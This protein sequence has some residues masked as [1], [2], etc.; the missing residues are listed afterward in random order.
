MIKRLKWKFVLINMLSVTAV[1]LTVFLAVFLTS[2]QSLRE[3]SMAVLERVIATDSAPSLFSSSGEVQIPYFTVR[4][5]SDGSAYLAGGSYY[6]FESQQ[7]LQ[8]ILEECLAQQQTSGVLER[9]HL[10]YLRSSSPFWEKIAFVD[11]SFE[12]ATLRSLSLSMLRF[13][14]P[15]LLALF[16]VSLLLAARAVRPVEASM[17]RQRQ[18]LSDASHELKTPLTVILSNT[19]LLQEELPEGESR[20]W[21]GNI[22]AESRRMKSLVEEM[23]TLERSEAPHAAPFAPL[24]LSELATEEVLRFEP[25]AFEAGKPLR[26]SIQE[27][28][29]LSGNAEQLHRLLA[30]LL[31]NA[32]RYGEAGQGIDVTL[33]QEG[34]RA[35]L[36][37]SNAAPPLTKEQL[38][39]LFE[40]F[41][42]S[43]ASRGEQSGFGLGLPIARAIARQ[44]GGDLKAESAA[45]RL[46]FTAS[47]PLRNA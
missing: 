41:Y 24:S 16:F 31:D 5:F 42:R 4:L 40:R 2:R 30:V 33:R 44:H 13:M 10:R 14:L 17:E 15:A 28:I 1:L 36:S 3:S 38:S 18:F 47:L 12:T 7:Q 32:I 37:V 29:T 11:T 21:L 27:N 25:L 22:E 45:G 6:A 20:R 34:R 19:A 46:T 9:Y 23:L 8:S 35:L 39:H 26:E 43:D